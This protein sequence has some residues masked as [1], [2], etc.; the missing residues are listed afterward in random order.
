VL[1][2]LLWAPIPSMFSHGCHLLSL[3]FISEM[4]SL[5]GAVSGCIHWRSR[6]QHILPTSFWD[7]VQVDS[8]S[9]LRRLGAFRCTEHIHTP[10]CTFC[11][12]DE[13]HWPKETPLA[14]NSSLRE[15]RAGTW[16]RGSQ[17]AAS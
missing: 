4:V 9:W 8:L 10:C 1:L 15:V 14:H 17:N 16:R 2:P 5:W 6:S 12:C 3:L 7:F 13:I 11:C